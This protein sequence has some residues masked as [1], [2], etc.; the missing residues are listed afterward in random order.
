MNVL[1]TIDIWT[2]TFELL[3]ETSEE[4]ESVYTGFSCVTIVVGSW[5]E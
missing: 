1:M 2:W 3:K 5:N 4:A